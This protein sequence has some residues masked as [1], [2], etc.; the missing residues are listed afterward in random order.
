MITLLDASVWL[1]AVNT[2][3]TA[4]NGASA[5]I[6]NAVAAGLPLA[7][8]DLTLYEATNVAIRSWRSRPHAELLVSLI[9]ASAEV[10]RVDTALIGASIDIAHEHS[11]T[12]Y[13]AAYVAAARLHGAVLVSG[14]VADLVSKG[15]AEPIPAA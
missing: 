5:L 12:V 4:H 11:L 14:D 1:A 10:I 2:D 7:A 15:L 13:D 3:E 6:E 8:L 9:D